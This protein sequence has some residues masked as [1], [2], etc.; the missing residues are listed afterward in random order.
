MKLRLAAK[1]KI[2]EIQRLNEEVRNNE[3]VFLNID[4]EI[5]KLLTDLKFEEEDILHDIMASESE[6]KRLGILSIQ[7]KNLIFSSYFMSLWKPNSV[8][9]NHAL[10]S[11]Y[12]VLALQ[13]WLKH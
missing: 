11:F 1:E 8:Y 7:I 6:L 3:D 9:V 10:L 5:S 12:L 13:H 2:H 4:T